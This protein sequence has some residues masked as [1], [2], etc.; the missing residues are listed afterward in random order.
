MT[1]VEQCGKVSITE[2]VRDIKSEIIRLRLKEKIEIL[3][4]NIKITTT[5]CNFGGQRYWFACPDCQKRCGTLYTNPINNKLSCRECHG[6]K[7][8]KSRFNKMK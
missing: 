4:Q 1:L 5:P 8:M 2:I 6:L 7:Y 3:S